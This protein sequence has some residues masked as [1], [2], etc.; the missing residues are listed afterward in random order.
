MLNQVDLLQYIDVVNDQR[1]E[2][3]S[4]TNWSGSSTMYKAAIV[5]EWCCVSAQQRSSCI[6]GD[7]TP[8]HPGVLQTV[9]CAVNT[10]ANKH[11]SYSIAQCTC[12]WWECSQS[13][14]L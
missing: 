12:I 1:F 10:S 11:R 4:A 8:V 2:G 6:Y 13:G 3:E 14:T 9:S 5:S 7:I